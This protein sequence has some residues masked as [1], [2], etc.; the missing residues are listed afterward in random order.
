M[1]AMGMA[2]LLGHED[3]SLEEVTLMV[4]HVHMLLLDSRFHLTG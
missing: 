2:R 4:Q 3:L 1:A